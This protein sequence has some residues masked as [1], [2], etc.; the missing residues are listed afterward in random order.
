MYFIEIFVNKL[1]E[2]FGMKGPQV[3]GRK[4]LKTQYAYNQEV[5][6]VMKKVNLIEKRYVLEK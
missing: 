4:I 1:L 2:D 6:K 3:K 5:K